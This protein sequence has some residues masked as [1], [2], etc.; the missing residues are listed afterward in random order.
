MFKPSNYTIENAL[1][2][3]LQGHFSAGDIVVGDNHVMKDHG[4]YIQINVDANT[5]KGHVSYDLF[6]DENDR[7]I[8]WEKHR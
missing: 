3:I 8:R 1:K 7:L 5:S 6:F 4:D 2:E